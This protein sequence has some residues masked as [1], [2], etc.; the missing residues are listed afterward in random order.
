MPGQ[1]VE[2][3]YAFDAQ[4]EPIEA[5]VAAASGDWMMYFAP[6]TVP[7]FESNRLTY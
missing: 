7:A 6:T 1:G 2:S 5:E 4:A 3:N